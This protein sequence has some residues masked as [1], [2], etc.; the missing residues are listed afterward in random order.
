MHSLT[1]MM[2][3]FPHMYFLPYECTH[4][5]IHHPLLLPLSLLSEPLP[6]PKTCLLGLRALLLEFE[7]VRFRAHPIHCSRGLGDAAEVIAGRE[8]E[9]RERRGNR[10]G[11]EARRRREE[12]RRVDRSWEKER[13][14][15]VGGRR[16]KE[17]EEERRRKR[18]TRRRKKKGGGG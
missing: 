17:E 3:P 10:E 15:R 12:K 7:S 9:E 8:K 4:S 11:R 14:R 5:H 18:E 13:E 16:R 2:F 6:Y 1:S